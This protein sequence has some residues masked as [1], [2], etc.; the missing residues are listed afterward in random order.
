MF[1]IIMILVLFLFLNIASTF[2]NEFILKSQ[3]LENT[4]EWLF[5]DAAIAV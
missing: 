1:L 3:T 5:V 2:E 4:G